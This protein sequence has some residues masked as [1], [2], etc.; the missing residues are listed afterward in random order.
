MMTSALV[1][2]VEGRVLR[3]EGKPVFRIGRAIEADVVLTAGSVSRRHAELRATDDGWVLVDAGSQFGTFVDDH[4]IS[5][6]RVS[7]RTVVRCGPP[8]AGSTLTL[9]PA[10]QYQPRA[11][12][13]G[14][15]PVAAPA[16]VP[17]PAPGR[18]SPYAPPSTPPPSMPA[19]PPAAPPSGPPTAA[20]G[21]Q[22][23]P[24]GARFAP[25]A[26]GTPAHGTPVPSTP[27]HGEQP[28]SGEPSQ[29]GA[30]PA[31]PPGSSV[32]LPGD[33]AT[34]VLAVARPQP[35]APGQP[36]VV[37]P[38]SGPDLLIV[39]EGRE[40]RFRHPAQITVGRRSDATV[41]LT[42]PSCSRMHGRIDAVPDGWVYVNLSNEGTFAD[43]RRVVQRRFDERLDL[44]LGHPVAGPELSLVPILSAVEEE[45]RIARRRLRR[46]LVVWGAVAAA[47]VL[48]IGV[49]AGAWFIAR[50]DG[51][52]RTAPPEGSASAD[53][54][55]STPA[56]LTPAEL[57]AAKAATVKITAE[58]HL[59]GDPSRTGTYHGSGSIIR[60]DGLILTNAHV[61]QPE[62]AGLSEQYGGDQIANPDF[63]LVSLTDGMTDTN[64]PAAYRARVVDADG[65]LDAAVLQIYANA[66]GSDLDGT[67]D[68]P[69]VPIGNSDDLRA[70]DDVTVLGF[71]AVAG[72][73]DSITVT[74]GVISTVLNDP[75]LG[76]RSELDTDARIAPGNSGGMAINNDGQLIGIPTALF[77]DA[78]TPVTS[79]RI[80]SIDAVKP[81]IRSAEDATS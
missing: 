61:A 16:P 6:H 30:R 24:A 76:P 52:L 26:P 15:P 78:D 48:A 36:G 51:S 22:P 79:G 35:G 46:Q 69:T 21:G 17:P 18:W 57:E 62:A 34:Q 49:L 56:Y 10:E 72:S 73:G 60:A 5:E 8:A 23:A 45:R 19:N 43:G 41:V 37:A 42:D 81:L 64:A 38:R 70:G 59:L 44:R 2:E 7:G 1:V 63:L 20:P 13:S 9:V 47:L 77:S 31:L 28:R 80:R 39:A 4:R 65:E 27:A 74:T 50:D 75:E 68:L 11:E 67:L 12:E 55:P 29:P 32:V 58:T 14:A 25:Q 3:L 54:D 53:G 66:D 40:H 71:P 33:D